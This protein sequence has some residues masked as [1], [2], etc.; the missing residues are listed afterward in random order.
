[1]QLREYQNLL[2][3]QQENNLSNSIT[4]KDYKKQQIIEKIKPLLLKGLTGREIKEKTGFCKNTINKYRQ[5]IYRY[6]I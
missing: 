5:L 1:M 3:A 6:Y 2:K 4:I